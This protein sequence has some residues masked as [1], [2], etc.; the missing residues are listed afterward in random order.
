MKVN[1]PL[2]DSEELFKDHH[3][4]HSKIDVP[5][6]E[7]QWF[8][9]QFSNKCNET[10]LNYVVSDWLEVYNT[11]ESCFPLQY[12]KHEF[13]REDQ[14]KNTWINWMDEVAGLLFN[15]VREIRLERFTFF[16]KKSL[17]IF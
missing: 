17:L 16:K 1:I 11:Y 12:F 2:I 14:L 7:R 6:A 8:E 13:E 3:K 15:T 10:K 9:R 4:G 5:E